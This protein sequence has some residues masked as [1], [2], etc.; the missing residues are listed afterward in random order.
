MLLRMTRM[1]RWWR[2]EKASASIE[3]WLLLKVVPLTIGKRLLPPIKKNCNSIFLV[4]EALNDDLM[5]FSSS[6]ISSTCLDQPQEKERRG[7]WVC[8]GRAV[9]N[10]WQEKEV[11]ISP[12]LLETSMRSRWLMR[13]QLD[14]ASNNN[15]ASSRWETI[16][17]WE[18]QENAGT[19]YNWLLRKVWLIV[20]FLT[21]F[22]W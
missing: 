10:V 5:S 16:S 15:L 17:R 2:K 21:I 22:F 9:K 8:Q 6:S 12:D 19:R 4:E 18:T 7:S 3:I 20:N 1:K 11:E 14:V 13:R